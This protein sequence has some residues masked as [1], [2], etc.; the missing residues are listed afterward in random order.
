MRTP[1]ERAWQGAPARDLAGHLPGRAATFRD[2]CETGDG[3]EF[4]RYRAAALGV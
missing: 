2:N 1:V 3:A 4:P